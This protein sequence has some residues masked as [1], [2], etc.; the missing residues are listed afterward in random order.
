MKVN[1]SVNK[2]YLKKAQGRDKSARM[3]RVNHTM[4]MGQSEC[5]LEICDIGRT[6]LLAGYC[7]AQT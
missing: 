1:N 5:P 4:Q 6:L 7:C 3:M 2:F